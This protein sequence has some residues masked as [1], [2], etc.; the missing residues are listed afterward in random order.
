MDL[1]PMEAIRRIVGRDVGPN[2]PSQAVGPRGPRDTREIAS[3]MIRSARVPKNQVDPLVDTALAAYERFKASGSP[4][5][6]RTSL[7]RF[8]DRNID[9]IADEAGV[10][11]SDA[12]KIKIR[13]VFRGRGQV[14]HLG[15]HGDTSSAHMSKSIGELRK[16]QKDWARSQIE[17]KDAFNK[18]ELY[19][20]KQAIKKS[21][22]EIGKEVYG[23]TLDFAK[24][25]WDG[26]EPAKPG[27]REAME[28]LRQ[29]LHRKPYMNSIPE[30]LKLRIALDEIPLKQRIDQDPVGTAHWLQSK[31]GQA[32]AD[33]SASGDRA[34]AGALGEARDRLLKELD[35]AAP[36]YEKARGDY[37]DEFRT[38]RAGEFGKG[39]F[40]DTL[41]PEDVAERADDY[42]KMTEKQKTLARMSTRDEI[43]TVFEGSPEEGMAR[44]AKIGSEG[45]LKALEKVF[46][47]P[48]KRVA[49]TIREIRNEMEWLNGN[50][51]LGLGGID[52]FTGSNSIN[53]AKTLI[54]DAAAIRNGPQGAVANFSDRTK[55]W[56]AIL[57]DAALMFGTGGAYHQPMMTAGVMGSKGVKAATT[58]SKRMLAN[59][60]EGIFGNPKRTII[61]DMEPP[62][63][64]TRSRRTNEPKPLPE[65]MR[66]LQEAY[67]ASKTKA[68][69]KRIGKKMAQ[70]HARGKASD[71]IKNGPVV[72]PDEF[73]AILKGGDEPPD[74]AGFGGRALNVPREQTGPEVGK[75]AQRPTITVGGTEMEPRDLLL[76]YTEGGELGRDRALALGLDPEATDVTNNLRVAESKL[77]SA[78]KPAVQAGMVDELAKAWNV[79]PGHIETFVNK[80]KPSFHGKAEA[81]ISAALD[82]IEKAAANGRPISLNEAARKVGMLPGTLKQYMARANN[83]RANDLALSKGIL[84]R[85]QS[86]RDNGLISGRETPRQK[87][88]KKTIIDDEERANSISAKPEVE[89]AAARVAQAGGFDKY[90]VRRQPQEADMD[91]NYSWWDI[92][93]GEKKVGD[94]VLG[95]N[96][97]GL[98]LGPRIAPELQRQGIG[99]ALYD[100]V[101]RATGQKLTPSDTLT[102]AGRALWESRGRKT[103]PDAAGFGGGKSLDMSEAGRM[104]RAR[105]QGFDVDKPLYHGTTHDFDEFGDANHNIESHHGGGIYLSSSPDDV[106]RNYATNKGADLTNR[107]E[108]RAERIQQ[109]LEDAV[110]DGVDHD[111]LRKY[112]VTEEQVTAR[113][114][115][116]LPKVEALAKELARKEIAGSHEGA[117]VPVYAR[118]KNPVITNGGTN[119]S[120]LRSQQPRAKPNAKPTRWDFE[121]QW[122]DA[123]EEVISEGGP[124]ADL[125]ASVERHLTDA[126][127]SEKHVGEVTSKLWNEISDNDGIDADAFERIMRN[128]P[129]AYIIDEG[130]SPGQI[131]QQV[132]RDMGHDGI[133]LKDADREF[134]NMGMEPGTEHTVVFDPENVR[135]RFA[136]FDPAKTKSRKL[137]AGVGGSIVDKVSPEAVGA[138]TGGAATAAAP[139]DTD[140]DGVVSDE[141]RAAHSASIAAGIMGGGAVGNI[142]R[143]MMKGPAKGSIVDQIVNDMRSGK[144]I[145]DIGKKHGLT[146]EQVKRVASLSDEAEAVSSRTFEAKDGTE[147][148]VNFDKSKN[149]VDVT[150]NANAGP[151]APKSLLVDEFKPTGKNTL[152]EANEVFAGVE[153]AIRQDIATNGAARYNLTGRTLRQREIYTQM[154]KRRAAPDGYTWEFGDKGQVALVKSGRPKAAGFHGR[155]ETSDAFTEAASA[156][157]VRQVQ[158]EAKDG[159]GRPTDVRLSYDSATGKLYA[160]NGFDMTH[161]EAS[162]MLG[163]EGDLRAVLKPGERL[164]NAK[165]FDAGG[166]EVDAPE[167]FK[168]KDEGIIVYRGSAD[169]EP[170]VTESG[171]LGLGKYAAEDPEIGAEWGGQS[172]KVDAYRVKGKLFDLDETSAQGIENYQKQEDTPA[173]RALKE[174]LKA[175]GYVGIRDPWSGHINVFDESAMVRAA[176]HDKELGS[177]WTNDD[178]I[179]AAGF[180]GKRASR[181]VSDDEILRASKELSESDFEIWKA[182]NSGKT[183]EQI[184]IAVGGP[185]GNLT[186]EQVSLRAHVIR[187]MGFD[188]PK[189]ARIQER[190]LSAETQKVIDLARKG[191]SNEDIYNR[192]YPGRDRT[193]A[194]KQIN[195]LRSQH[196]ATIL[197]GN[198]QPPTIIDNE[199]LSRSRSV[200]D[201]MIVEASKSLNQKEFDVFRL[202]QKGETTNSIAKQLGI[203]PREVTD[204]VS[205]MRKKGVEIERVDRG[206]ARKET[207]NRVLDLIA[208]NKSREEIAKEVFPNLE[209]KDGASRVRI[210]ANNYRKQIAEKFKV[211]S[212]SFGGVNAKTADKVAL[213]YAQHM[214]RKGA[215][216]EKIIKETGWWRGLDGKW[217]FEIDDSGAD[218][219]AS[220][221]RKFKKEGKLVI[222][223]EGNK[224]AFLI[225]NFKHDKAEKAYPG[226]SYATA[227]GTIAPGKETSGGYRPSK[228][229]TMVG[230]QVIIDAP[231]LQKGR[232]AIL[233]EGTHGI[234]DTEDFAMGATAA[235]FTE[236]EVAAEAARLAKRDSVDLANEG[237]TTNDLYTE[238]ARESLY[239]RQAGE[240]EARNVVRRDELRR[241]GKEPG[242]PWETEDVPADEQIVRTDAPAGDMRGEA[243]PRQQD[244]NV[245]DEQPANAPQTNDDFLVRG[246]KRERNFTPGDMIDAYLEGKSH[247]DIALDMGLDP[248]D[249]DATALARQLSKN[250]RRAVEGAQA[251]GRLEDMAKA[252]D[253]D[254]D[255]LERFVEKRPHGVKQEQWLSDLASMVEDAGAKG[256]SIGYEAIA[257]R[258]AAKGH[259][260]S[261]GTLKTV[262]SEA[263][264]GKRPISNEL[265]ERLKKIRVTAARSLSVV[266]GAALAGSLIE[267]DDKKTII[268][269]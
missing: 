131:I 45:N 51:E 57:A 141:E 122:D 160:Y 130:G 70:V 75:Y 248:E 167:L 145:E 210:I 56:G 54:D 191:Y 93:D 97:K 34:M 7:G 203:A 37:G 193:K 230:R 185:D 157:D 168:P 125:V 90:T 24:Q 241:A 69:R 14:A 76:A 117:T 171:R 142:A 65:T 103:P 147:Y 232:S 60:T 58:P 79:D 164:K 238:M 72:T 162:Q 149:G 166:K 269:R 226:Y 223:G 246:F 44:I 212:A 192:V 25:V 184:A 35:A 78:L 120:G 96:G 77:R 55:V 64:K 214:E 30:D 134:K 234:Q 18:T 170:G 13:Q 259:E 92:Y 2:S 263:R 101:E 121:T 135:G 38:L 27:E 123:G 209:P 86:A 85:V 208:Q 39:W 6:E 87:S 94:F 19:D 83:N 102:S 152:A 12:T 98:G 176:E 1:T 186:P 132:Y 155:N 20:Q 247:R 109:E 150:F 73:A 198:K 59:S 218:F 252:W 244:V 140:G 227:K 151:K 17:A 256:K 213:R 258:L 264:N 242:Y 172:G 115:S 84:A 174:R 88:A 36:A 3:R 243:Q 43:M 128:E 255:Q 41:R 144:P 68:E 21:A 126:G 61:D 110:S 146:A 169:D 29:Y 202:L 104:Q 265:R 106:A 190:G 124:A 48:G 257:K 211:D 116:G 267:D 71:G 8:I 113:T 28:K 239:N 233:H 163:I 188:V 114:N 215:S 159:I 161:G 206:P 4:S 139:A 268:D 253:V 26:V 217:R 183:N 182:A 179:D 23:P 200:T 229:G 207:T 91:P 89:A 5:V 178:D 153:K 156:D 82:V 138:V 52:A 225:D 10:Q 177:T 9:S 228:Y 236:D 108:Q 133:I 31:F 99:S 262:L 50:K 32:A 67:A 189:A 173:G 112:G 261:T 129:A 40:T 80:L 195:V 165:W 221:K 148:V 105:E 250:V 220:A 175:E 154:A 107:I 216:R 53:K 249:V 62:A 197:D 199:D 118:L 222:G 137:L 196:K 66:E 201:E 49:D 95:N 251:T 100:F 16:T 240:V 231:D 224:G 42:A 127:M 111:V 158:R 181:K 254:V 81:N 143:R 63:P 266:G 260:V 205:D 245:P 187:K 22:E 46:G 235:S 33:R 180:S 194:I 237:P 119:P 136:E 204:A 47:A 74:A 15:E 219:R 11:M